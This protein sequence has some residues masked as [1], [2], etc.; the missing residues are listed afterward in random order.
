MNS[1][2]LDL[3]AIF[4]DWQSLPGTVS[5]LHAAGIETVTVLSPVPC[6]E[7]EPELSRGESPVR[8]FTLGGAIAGAATGLL[9]TVGATLQYPMIT[10]GKPIVS[11]PPFLVI[12]FELTIL[13]GALATL[14]GLFW[15]IRRSS[16]GREALYDP[17]F[18]VDRF[19]I[20]VLCRETQR[21]MVS[22]I[23]NSAGALEV[24]DEKI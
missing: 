17:Q 13:F 22:R 2:Y 8:F 3:L 21:E 15:Q 6:P 12:T 23:L 20:R 18:S 19:G 16:R 9:L 14:A 11:V 7:V 4:D 5:S 24:R 10:G 1:R